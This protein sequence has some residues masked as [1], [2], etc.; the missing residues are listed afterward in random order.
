MT[1]KF[2]V[3]LLVSMMSTSQALAL[4]TVLAIRCDTCTDEQF[5][6]RA[7][8][9]GSGI[10]YLYDFSGQ[11]LRSFKVSREPAPGGKF[12]YEAIEESVPAEYVA[13]FNKASDYRQRYGSLK[14]VVT[15]NLPQVS[16]PHSGMSV[17]DVYETAGSSANLGNWL[18]RFV[19]T[20]AANND[21]GQRMIDMKN[22]GSQVRFQE[23]PL[24]AKIFVNFKDGRA[25]F[26]LSENG[27]TCR[28][29]PNTVFDTH[30]NPIPGSRSQFSELPYNFPG[31]R[32]S[33]SYQE[34]MELVQRLGIPVGTSSGMWACTSVAGLGETCRLVR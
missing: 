29:V 23:D 6:Q 15:V 9:L 24:T 19:S 20:A 22:D 32:T 3:F 26:E 10:H 16:G 18:A 1:R 30:N 25:E 33:A 5:E 27:E 28:L 34:F 11:Q 31:G 2:L 7:I 13:F 4:P 8:G 21:A 17:F 12:V 14:L